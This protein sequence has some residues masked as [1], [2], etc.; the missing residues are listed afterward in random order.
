MIFITKHFASRHRPVGDITSADMDSLREQDCLTF[1]I[2]LN[3]WQL[4]LIRVG[5]CGA[6]KVLAIVYHRKIIKTKRR[7]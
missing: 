4:L 5:G 2:F 6:I 7:F 1:R 3:P